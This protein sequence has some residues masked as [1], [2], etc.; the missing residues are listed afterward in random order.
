VFWGEMSGRAVG[1]G[2]VGSVVGAEPRSVG[3][4]WVQA[5]GAMVTV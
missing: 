4:G 2:R 3:C 1:L 5:A